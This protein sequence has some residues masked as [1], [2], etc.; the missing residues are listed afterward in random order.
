QAAGQ[1]AA[2]PAG[3]VFA[4]QRDRRAADDRTRYDRRRPAHE[5]S[6]QRQGRGSRS[7]RQ[8]ED[9]CADDGHHHR[10]AARSSICDLRRVLQRHLPVDRNGGFS[11]QR[12]RLFPAVKRYRDGNHVMMKELVELL[13]NRKM[14]IASCE[15]L[16]AVLFTSR[17]A[18]VP[19][20]S[21]VLLGGI[22]TYAT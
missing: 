17:I 4:D 19:G 5:C 2:D 8:G 20:A 3:V 7:C 12:G 10:P 21:A 1:Y 6:E 13:K 22:V 14:T 9:G 15:S 11:V 18:E 16:T